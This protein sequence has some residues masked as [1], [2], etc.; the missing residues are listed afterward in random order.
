LKNYVKVIK[1]SKLEN[2]FRIRKD[3]KDLEANM[4][5]QINFEEL[6]D[7]YTPEAKFYLCSRVPPNFARFENYQDCKA[8]TPN[9]IL[10]QD[11]KSGYFSQAVLKEMLKK[12]LNVPTCRALL[13]HIRAE[14]K[15]RSVYLVSDL[16]AGLLLNI[17]GNIK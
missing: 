1:A 15:D 16:P 6:K 3:Y 11:Y 12:Q 8:L 5:Q 4:I 17:I 13:S 9:L 7:M 2:V 10:L 14:A